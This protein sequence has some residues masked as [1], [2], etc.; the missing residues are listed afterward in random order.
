MSELR[1]PLD[2]CNPG[3]FYACCGLVE[4]FDLH[5]AQTLSCFKLDPR[6]PRQAI[7]AITSAASLHLSDVLT[8][9]KKARC[10]AVLRHKPEA[11]RKRRSGQPERNEPG[12][13]DST[14]PL[15]VSLQE[16]TITLD[17]WLDEYWDEKSDLKFWAGN[18]S[19]LQ[20]F[21]TLSQ[22]IAPASDAQEIF[23]SVA[24]AKG[25]FGVDPRS[26]WEALDLGYSPNEQSQA[27]RTYPSVE[28]LAAVGLEGYR[29]M[30]SRRDGLRYSLWLSPLSRPATRSACMQGW[31]GLPCVAYGF[32]LEG[33]GSYKY[34]TF[35]ER[36]FSP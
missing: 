29:P 25:R 7:F 33:R 22:L 28:V 11:F 35:A 32:R 2:P 18:Q 14:A 1:F 21:T 23:E 4:L 9:L 19:S 13:K 30:G 3:Q 10:N 8:A 31:N 17:W 6:L 5:G 24:M 26:A 34:F 16:Q 15:L 20:I 12:G 27:V 36:L